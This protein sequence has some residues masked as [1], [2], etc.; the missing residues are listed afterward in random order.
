MVERR[1]PNPQVEGS[2][3]SR[4]AIFTEA[5]IMDDATFELLK[6]ID[7]AFDKDHPGYGETI[8]YGHG[9]HIGNDGGDHLRHD[10]MQAVEAERRR[11]GR[12]TESALALSNTRPCRDDY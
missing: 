7:A 2:T 10:I 12:I 8:A 1:T 6:R 11:R 4:P 9:L 3:P 5:I